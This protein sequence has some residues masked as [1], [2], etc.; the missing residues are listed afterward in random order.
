MDFVRKL[1]KGETAVGGAEAKGQSSDSVWV[2]E[3]T[4]KEEEVEVEEMGYWGQLEKEWQDL[5]K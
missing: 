2:S 5:A 1:G 3:F 4:G